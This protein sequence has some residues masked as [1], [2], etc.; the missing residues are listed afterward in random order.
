MSDS[1]NTATRQRQVRQ[2]ALRQQLSAQGHVQHVIDMVDKIRDETNDLEQDMVARYKIAIDTKLKLVN[3]YL[4]DMRYIET[5]GNELEELSDAELDAYIARL[6][7]ELSEGN[8][9]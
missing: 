1:R 8:S 7:A 3:K 9:A 2:E 6:D 5:S 4:P